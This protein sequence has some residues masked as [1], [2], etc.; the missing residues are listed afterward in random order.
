MTTTVS[1]P[2]DVSD[3]RWLAIYILKTNYCYLVR[4]TRFFFFFFGNLCYSAIT[5]L[6]FADQLVIFMFFA[7]LFELKRKI[8]FE[9]GP[10]VDH[11]AVCN[12][13]A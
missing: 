5:L 8:K 12:L 7:V 13:T 6:S 9:V 10:N 2:E 4:F 1:L 11:L 3:F